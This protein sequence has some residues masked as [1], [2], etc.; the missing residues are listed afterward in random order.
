MDALITKMS[1]E[2]LCHTLKQLLKWL[3]L[4]RAVWHLLSC[5]FKLNLRLD[6]NQ[7]LDMVQSYVRLLNKWTYYVIT[8]VVDVH[9]FLNVWDRSPPK[10]EW[11]PNQ[12]TIGSWKN[13]QKKTRWKQTIYHMR[14]HGLRWIIVK[15][16]FLL[17]NL[18][19]HSSNHVV[20][21]W[22]IAAVMK[23]SI[24]PWMSCAEA[25]D[26]RKFKPWYPNA[27]EMQQHPCQVSFVK[28]RY[29]KFI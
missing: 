13:H 18:T 2:F 6:M 26:R 5:W 14:S 4:M 8:M 22:G 1:H 10:L 29:H 7:W 17:W 19:G 20:P 15:H 12:C 3:A 25:F 23:G 24:T 16:V 21:S 27:L 9:L 11:F 28:A